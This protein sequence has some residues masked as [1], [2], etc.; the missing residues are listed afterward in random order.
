[1]ENNK[2]GITSLGAYLPY[3]Y[4]DRS[5]LGAAWGIRGKG[6]KSFGNS[7]EDSVTMAVEAAMDCFRYIDRKDIDGLH[8]SSTTVPYAEKSHATLIGT[9]LD[10]KKNIITSDF[11]SSMRSATSALRAAYS[12]VKSGGSDNVLVV[13]SDTRNGYPKSGQE[14]YFGDGSAAVVVGK[15]NVIATIDAFSSVQTEIVDMWRNTEDVYVRNAE[16]RFAYEEGYLESVKEV[17]GNV[18]S[19]TGLTID[20]F[21]GVVLVSVDEKSH[22]K[23]AR[24][25]KIPTEKIVNANFSHTGVLGVSQPL[26][27]LVE[28]IEKAE[29]NDRILLIN[30]G[31]GA[32]AVVLT[33]TEQKNKVI[34]ENSVE[35]YL[36]NRSEF[37]EYGRFLSFRGIIEANPGEDYKIPASTS[38]SWREQETYLKLYASKCDDCGQHI[39]PQNRICPNCKSLDHYTK[40]NK[41]EEI[42]QLFTYSIDNLAGRSDDPVIVQSITEDKDGTRYYLNMTDFDKD[43]VSVG[44]DLEFTFRKIHDLADFPNYY[45]KVRPIRRKVNNFGN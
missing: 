14:Q 25:L 15:G 28:A 30:Y 37:K 6:M 39:F 34:K 13:A 20:D 19:E 27:G 17:Y 22:L 1:M 44:M 32:D 42:S 4:F 16:G 2:I 43:N 18:L 26:F 7:D 35:K 3:Y 33:V 24:K 11:T 41:S 21:N 10:L 31:N 29:T 12:E 5:N 45:W 8:F 38:Q 23:A 36:N 40:V 9:V